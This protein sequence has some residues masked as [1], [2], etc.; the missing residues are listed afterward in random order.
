MK[1]SLKWLKDYVDIDVT[2]EELAQQM[3]MLG[4]EIESIEQ[5]GGDITNTVVGQILSIEPHPDADKLVVCRTDAGRAQPEQIVCGAKNMKVGDKVPTALL[6]AS[7]PGGFKIERRKMRGVES[8]GMMCSNRELGLGEDQA[9]LMILDPAL[10]VGQ[11]IKEALGIGD[12][13]F[14][15][16]VIP[17]RGDWASM[18]GVARELAALYGKTC[19]IPVIDIKE[20]SEP[21]KNVSSV[22]IEDADLCPRYIGR[23]LKH[24]KVGPSP[25]WLAQRLVAAGQR[26]INNIVDI[27]N[28]VL[29]ETGHPLHA[30]DCE[31]LA[32]HRIVV[33]RAHPGETINTLDGV[34]RSLRPEMLVIADAQR[35]QAVAGVMGG[36]DSEV[37]ENTTTILLESAVFHPIAVR[38]TSRALGLVTEAAQHFQRGADPEMA[39]YAIDRAAQLM[40][41]LAG[42]EILSGALDEYPQPAP[43]REARLRYARCNQVLG[44]EI[45]SEDQRRYLESLSFQTIAQN[46]GSATFR[47]P[48]WRHDVTLEEDLIEEIA[49]LFGYGNIPTV[50]PKVHPADTIL[51][52][53]EIR[54]RALRRFLAGQGLTELYNWTFSCPESVLKAGIQD[55]HGEMVT[56]E[57]PLSEKQATMRSS[58]IPGLL[59]N[60]A[61]N[62]RHGQSSMAAFELGPVYVPEDGLPSQKQ[63]LAILLTGSFEPKHWSR[64][65]SPA[66]LFDLKGLLESLFGFLGTEVRFE[67]G[68]FGPLRKGQTA[69]V[70]TETASLGWCGQVRM[71]VLKKWDIE[72]DV[73]LAEIDL[74]PL[75]DREKEAKKFSAIHGF[76][77]VLRDLAIL[78]DRKIPAGTILEAARQAG[79]KDLR[80]AEVFDIYTGKQIDTDKKSVALSFVF[81]SETQTLTDVSTQKQIDRVTKRLQKDFGATLR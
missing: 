23:I 4:L 25:Q 34:S 30:F 67:A 3:T 21:A 31:K 56:L 81:Q 24:V 59:A 51:A 22:T 7:L 74:D 53:Q 61:H 33:R 44:A 72:T 12:V 45:P 47:I 50:L 42:A 63:R 15:I 69:Q 28:Y 18:I 41:E 38:R 36:A 40:Q 27:T 65:A 26:P 39:R 48:A 77:P 11:D 66:D 57:N 5:L 62:V 35:P 60:A 70:L 55:T 64:P 9:G 68:E 46:G 43:A 6:G 37:G 54:I 17:N 32:E 49:R 79:G 1:I 20:S 71:D 10:P 29:L 75:L 73:F 76:P 8:C 13:I 2:P 52:P 19:R 14:E 16:E 78:V 80:Q 58:L